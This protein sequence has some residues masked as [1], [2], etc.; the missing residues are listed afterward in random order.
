[1]KFSS[2]AVIILFLANFSLAQGD[3]KTKNFE[4]WTK[5]DVET[6]LNN[7]DWSKSQKILLR[8][9]NES[10]IDS[11]TQANT[12]VIGDVGVIRENE[13]NIVREQNSKI[14]TIS[15]KTEFIFTL[16]LRSSMAIRLALI[17][18]NELETDMTKLTKEEIDLFKKKQRGLFDCPGCVENYVL[19]LSAK[20]NENKNFDPIYK[21]FANAKFDELKKYIYLLNDKGEKRE[22]THFVAPKAPTEEAYFFFSRLDEKQQPLFNIESKF[23]FFNSTNNSLKTVTNFKIGIKPIIVGE[24]VD[25]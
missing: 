8:D 17:R 22:M 15:P 7:S 1:M 16:R 23:L 2:L 14:E 25:F 19:T 4:T 9:F 18:K 5:Q 13:I 10:F 12:P 20:S 11:R 6:I 21:I 3:W 24:K